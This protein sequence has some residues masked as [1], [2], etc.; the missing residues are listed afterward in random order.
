MQAATTTSYPATTTSIYIYI[1]TSSN[2]HRVFFNNN[3]HR[4]KSSRFK[5]DDD[6]NANDSEEGDEESE[7]NGDA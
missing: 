4:V 3:I 7:G 1:C 6:D 5:T 2:I